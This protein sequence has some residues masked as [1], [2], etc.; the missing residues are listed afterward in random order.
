MRCARMTTRFGF[1]GFLLSV[2]V[3]PAW[4]Q[5][6]LHV[7]PARRFTWQDLVDQELVATQEEATV[8]PREAPE[9][10]RVQTRYVPSPSLRD[11]GDTAGGLPIVPAPQALCPG[12]PSWPGH[13]GAFGFQGL[14]DDNSALP[15]DTMG[16]VG[17]RHVMT[18]LNTQVRIHNRSG[19]VTYSTVSLATFWAGLSGPF[20]PKV[21]YDNLSGRW[22]AVGLGSKQS[23]GSAWEIAISSTNDP[24]GAW[25]SYHLDGD[26]ANTRWV[27]FP[28]VGFNDK[29]VAV[30]FNALAV[31]GVMPAPVTGAKMW[32]F[33]KPQLLAGG[34]LGFIEF[35]VDF[36]VDSGSSLQPAV[37]MEPGVADLYILDSSGWMGDPNGNTNW[38]RMS[39]ITG[40]AEA[41]SWSAVPGSNTTQAGFFPVQNR[42]SN[43]ML[44][45]S[46]RDASTGLD[47]GDTRMCNVVYRNGRIWAVHGGGYPAD[48]PDRNALYWYELQPSLPNPIVQSGIIQSGGPDAHYIYPSIAVSCGNDVCIGFSSTSPAI[49]PSAC[50]VTRLAGDA[51]GTT[52]PTQ[53]IKDGLAKYVK[54]GT[55]TRNRWGDYS[56]TVVDPLDD[57]SFWTL[58]EYAVQPF[59]GV[60]RWAVEW[61]QITY[62]CAAPGITEHPLS[63]Q[64]CPGQ[65]VTFSV[66]ATGDVA[67]YQ[68]NKNGQPILGATFYSYTIPSV[69]DTDAGDYTCTVIGLCK[70]VTSNPAML[71]VLTPPVVTGFVA[72]P[73]ATC[74]GTDAVII[75]AVPDSGSFP[76]TVT[77][78][79]LNGVTWQ[80]VPGRTI[81]YGNLFAFTPLV[82][83]DT[84]DYRL[85]YTNA[86]GSDYTGEHRIQVGV[87]FDQPPSA[88]APTPCGSGEFSV[89]A[90]GIGSL[91][92]QWRHDGVDLADDGRIAGA[93]TPALSIDR[94]RYEDE[95]L[96]E[97]AVTDDC[98]T[99]PS[100]AASLALPTPT[101]FARNEI[102]RAPQRRWTAYV[103]DEDRHVGV[104]YGGISPSGTYL[105]DHWEYDGVE[106]IER[107]PPQK[108]PQRYQHAMVYD[109]DRKRVYLFGGLQTVA[110]YGY[111]NDLWEYDGNTWT[112]RKPTT[113]P[114]NPPTFVSIHDIVMAY[115]SIRK[116]VVMVTAYA[117]GQTNNSK[118]FEYDPA[119][120]MWSERVASNGFPGGYK[121]AIAFDP[122]IG[123]CVYYYSLFDAQ[124][125]TWRWDGNVWAKDPTTAPYLF[126]SEMAYDSTRRRDVLFSHY[127][128]QSVFP[129]ESW[130]YSHFGW[131]RLLPAGPPD[132]PPNDLWAIRMAYDTR[133]R[134]MVALMVDYDTLASNVPFD[135]WEFRY[136]DGVVF[137]RQPAAQPLAPGAEVAFDVIAAGYGTLNY[138]WQRDGEDLVDGPALG[139][140]TLAGTQTPTLTITGVQAA[141]RGAYACAVSNACGSAL[142]DSASL[143]STVASDFD[144]DG[145]VDLADFTVFLACFNGPQRAP[146]QPGCEAVDF[147]HDNDVD[148]SDFTV[149]LSCFNGPQRPPACA[150]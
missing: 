67:Q 135:V 97:C 103:Y 47:A 75:P 137:D 80:D 91:S 70:A 129:T 60:D 30:T 37:C 110:P 130:Y 54:L 15:P 35:D 65:P 144:G 79:K 6:A 10:E 58:Q 41:P 147:D 51:P 26:A 149:F 106:W 50:Y 99:R 100:A 124:K 66:V 127:Q 40:T 74:P 133:R 85:K 20:D 78:Q 143:G 8:V 18:M 114:D 111:V 73:N 96:Y 7:E 71:T 24:T 44:P 27:D 31:P 56:A 128:S 140:G 46:Q 138:Q 123:Q 16:A 136:R 119:A 28:C 83:D 61:A 126:D 115:D 84:G 55:G 1:V 32:V 107:T 88:Q 134:A 142:S 125:Q 49:Y 33:N 86:C 77:L 150:P 95:G 116:K 14:G 3:E 76:M 141:D 121:D 23:A 89:V 63:Q 11:L 117:N 68:W 98:E 53:Y 13:S 19:G 2:A 94:L 81:D 57:K 9:H 109:S 52:S 82:H 105:Q 5:V 92:Y 139:G 36:D 101:W 145:D 12:F 87:S 4:A 69:L 48:A 17:P 146:A 45:A 102:P 39:R 59:G 90:R 93:N 21:F 34:T 148:L 131:T 43:T 29:W 62:G 72:W 108:P 120:N 64:I 113:D 118:T 112:L 42:F 132:S 122:V 38:L 22:I 25:T 104:L